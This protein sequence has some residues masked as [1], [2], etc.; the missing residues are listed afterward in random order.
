[1]KIFPKMKVSDLINEMGKSR[2]LGAG[3]VYKAAKILRKMFNDKDMNVFLSL[4]G[5][6]VPGGMRQIIA[7]LVKQGKID[8]IISS[9]ANLTHDLLEAFGGAHYRGKGFDDKKLRKKSIGRIG[10]IYT[11]SDD[12]EIFEEK[13]NIIFKKIAKKKKIISIREL[14]Y[15]IG[16]YLDDKNSI[17]KNAT[18]KNVPIYSPGIIDSMIGLQLWMFTQENELHLDAVADMHHLSDVVF[19]S[20]KIGAIIL[21][22][23]LPKHYT[24][25]STILRG[26]IDA[27][28]QIT[29]D[30]GEG[31]SLSGAPLEEAISWGKARANADLVTVV[32]DVTIIFPLLV[33]AAIDEG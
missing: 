23:G 19:S 32:G 10:D 17:I 18:E 27:G 8:V 13:I 22:G 26:G 21:G 15:E 25:A 11:K 5:P 2:V 20:K 28:I 24:I 12:F 29:T 7:D 16:K 3:K 9:G 14:L 1:M 30:R 31:G 6:L 33:A 4:A